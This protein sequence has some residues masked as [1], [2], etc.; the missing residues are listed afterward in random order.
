MPVIQLSLTRLGQYCKKKADEKKI[1][2]T[3]PYLGLDIEDQSGDIVSVEYS[4]NRPDF[5]SEAGIARSL[6]GILGIETGDPKYLFVPSK[7]KISLTGDEIKGVRPYIHAL[8]AEIPVTD[9]LVKQLITMQEDLHNGIGRRRSKVAIGI[10]NAE[11]VTNQIKYY[12]TKDGNFSFV[13]LGTNERK[14]VSQIL[15]ATEQGVSYGKLLSGTFPILEDSRG[16]VLSMPPIINGELTRL[17]AGQSKLFVDVTGTDDRAVDTSIAII[18]AMLSDASGRVQSVEIQR[19]QGSVWTPNMTPKTMRFDLE[20]T[21]NVIGYDFTMRE[22]EHALGRSRIGTYSNGSAVIP[23]YRHDIIHPIDLVEEVAL[24]FGIQLIKPQGLQT[25][26]VGLF[27]KR[28]NKLNRVIE[29]LVGLGLTEIWNLSLT[30]ADQVPQ[31]ALK[32]ENSKSQSFEYLRSDIIGSLLSV[33][34]SSTHQEY[35]QKVF[36]QATVFKSSSETVSSVSEEEHAAVLVAD[37]EANYTMIRSIID[38]LLRLT[39]DE[40][41]IVAFRSVSENTGAF[42]A[43]RAA[44]VSVSGRETGTIDIGIVG[45]ISP[46]MLEKYGLKVPAVG[47]EISLEP[48]LKG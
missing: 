44:F 3:L 43:G 1:L 33:L 18:A 13:P 35:P 26:L 7:Y 41:D 21:K 10:H 37:S 42:A 39:L 17:A 28:Q 11:K 31:D 25:S 48:L 9:E 38:G 30:S 46:H 20:L 15:E 12:A 22:A 36:E 14:T 45:E 24:G 29:T 2:E 32:V 27:S 40:N 6:V 5:S 8:Y 4:P 23:R 19:V 34:G 47:F 16:N